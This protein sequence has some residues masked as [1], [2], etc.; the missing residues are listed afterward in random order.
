MT[1]SPDPAPNSGHR[2]PSFQRRL[3]RVL[4]SRTSLTLGAILLVGVA[5]AGAYAWFFVREQL[6]PLVEKSLTET[7]KRPV[8]LGRVERFSWNGLRF[9]ASA[10]PATAADPDR[11]TV[12]ALDIGFNPLRLLLTRTL[13]LDVT[14]VRPTVYIEQD[15][16]GV[17]IA[18]T[19]QSEEQLGLIKTEFDVIRV[20][21]ANVVLSPYTPGKARNPIAIAPVN[22]TANFSGTGKERR[23]ALDAA[24]QFAKGGGFTL[25]GEAVPET[26]RANLQIQAQDVS[27]VELAKLVNVPVSVES[28][29]VS[30]DLTLQTRQD[31][32]P[33]LAGTADFS[34]ITAKIAGIPERLTNTQGR[35]RLNGEL[36]TLEQVST[37]YAGIPI[38]AQGTFHLKTGYNLTAQVP[39]VT[40][41]KLLSVLKAKSPIALEGEVKA[42]VRVTG[43]VDKPIL[44][45]IVSTTRPARVDK[46]TF[47]RVN[48]RF[49]LANAVLSVPL[50]QATPTI[51][52]EVIGRGQL[53]L[54]PQGRLS[55]VAQGQGIPG[56]AAAR[57]YNASLPFTVGTVAAQARITGTVG[58]PRTEVRFQAPNA[59]Y[60]GSGELFLAGSDVF[61]RNSTFQINGGTVKAQGRVSQG[62][63][64][65]VVQ[66]DRIA[67]N[68]FSRDLRGV[69][70]GRFSLSGTLAALRPSAI[71]AVGQ[72][73]LSQGISLIDT[74]LTALVRWDGS[75]ILVEQATATGFSANGAIVA[76]LEGAGAPRITGLDLNVQARN[77][78]VRRLPV[79]LPNGA[80][81][82]GLADFTG[83]LTGTP[84]APNVAGRLQLNQLAVNGVAFEPVLRGTV[85][86]ASGRGANLNLAGVRGDRIVVA[87]DRNNQPQT[88]F[89]Q[90]DQAVAVGRTE[91]DRLL[92]NVKDFPIAALNIIPG[93]ATAGLGAV[94]GRLTGDLAIN[95]RQG[96][97]EGEVAIAN[98]RLGSFS[99]D[100]FR[101]RL[102]YANGVGTLT[103]G[104]LRLGTSRYLITGNVTPGANPQ[105]NGKVS[106]PQGKLEDLL[107]ALQW[108]DLDDPLRGLRP[109]TYSR[110][111]AVQTVPVGSSTDTLLLQLRR[112]S[113]IQTLLRQQ[114]AQRESF[115]LPKLSELTGTF[116]GDI[117]IAGS[118]RPGLNLGFNLQGQDWKWGNFFANQVVLNGDFQNGILTLQPVRFQS[119]DTL[120]AFTGQVGGKTQS[121]QL[122]V[123][124]LPVERLQD[125]FPLP[126]NITGKLNGTATLAGSLFNPQ[127]LGD[128]SLAEG[129]LNNTPVETARASF[130]YRNSRLSFGS[131]IAI[132]GPEPI[133]II[134]SIPFQP[135]LLFPAPESDQID[136]SIRVQNEGLALLNLFNNQVAWIDGKGQVSLKVQGTLE[137]P[138]ATGTAQIENATLKVQALPDPLTNVNATARFASDRIVVENAQGQFSQGQVSAQ[139]VIPIVTAL[140]ATDPDVGNPL[141]LTLDTLAINLRGLYRGRVDGGVVVTGTALAPRIGGEIRVSNGQV[142]L[143]DETSAVAP[144][145]SGTTPGEV[146]PVELNNL[147]IALGE[148][149]QV[150]RQPILNFVA[151]GDLTVNGNLSAL[152]PEGVIQLRAGQVNL[153]ASRFTLESGYE[154]TARFDPANGL[155]PILDI[156]LITSVPEVTRVP[157]SQNTSSSEI[158]DIP[159]SSLGALQTIRIQARVTG[160]ASQLAENLEL[161]S[162]PSRTQ[163]EITGLLGGGFVNTLGR[164]GDGTLALANL[165]GSVFLTQLQGV[166]GN[167]LGFGE[168]RL[169]PT[170]LTSSQRNRT[171]STLGLAAELAVDITPTISAS[172]LRV[173]TA[174]VPTQYGLR[175]RVN[176]RVLVRGSSDFSG[177]SRAVVEYEARF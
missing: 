7:L 173:L 58:Y 103:G 101:G 113:E 47:S 35:L 106:I 31:Q 124:N 69:L 1:Q 136:L 88:F 65:A 78:D 111:A 52:G 19:I 28:G 117:R 9:G 4:F 85:N 154:H 162:S 147:R 34:G 55:F 169:F 107:V 61:L 97:I 12:E 73:Q 151:T 50:L 105:F 127:A 120:I 135:L 84:E 126:L 72:V 45:G 74:P 38:Q 166:L 43:A 14:A 44:S 21:S 167:A 59:T 3:R 80:A 37:T 91:G 108:F 82:V 23:V 155:D 53:A 123:Q 165:A 25:R 163:T 158:A 141:T 18:P 174:D 86:L 54:S 87:L 89:I 29:V 114:V 20:E 56:D 62:R 121:G 128:L 100:E 5:G 144:T 15:E 109:A 171:P 176:D 13:N 90:R 27:V 112:F 60:P 177:D 116:S 83:R 104:E 139:G 138:I 92:V 132:R 26:Q 10:L 2:P 137:R 22:V 6:A 49:R 143:P 125:F 175:Y 159:T 130:N 156:R 39:P 150:T 81:I 146:S 153:F 122:Q 115:P 77:Y 118:L 119:G 11:L 30:A 8:Q 51:G 133:Q 152:R 170:V 17:W 129:T 24:G 76:Q 98:P 96:T 79:A 94:S 36:V 64:Q 134:G 164:G 93:G 16:K 68:R 33:L 157:I 149:V 168:L 42:D 57:L 32:T 99:G 67:L 66:G 160:P 71:R 131:T 63:W 148:N 48:A 95:L 102:R 70:N 161:T 142:L 41:R 140:A 110:A 172:V 40:V 75:R 46:V 145:Q